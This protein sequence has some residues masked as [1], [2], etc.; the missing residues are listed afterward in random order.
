MRKRNK[1]KCKKEKQIQMKENT[2]SNVLHVYVCDV[3]KEK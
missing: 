2:K 1:S 3:L